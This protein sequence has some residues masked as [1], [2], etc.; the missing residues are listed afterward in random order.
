MDET[1]EIK[2]TA[3]N[4]AVDQLYDLFEE[5]RVSVATLVFIEILLM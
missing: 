5:G 4:A 2:A 3:F 1:G